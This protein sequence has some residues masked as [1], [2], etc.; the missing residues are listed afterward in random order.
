[1]NTRGEKNKLHN[2]MKNKTGLQP[3]SRTCG[4]NYWFFAA[5]KKRELKR[6]LY[7]TNS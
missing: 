1:M 7:L 6:H 2:V 3:V 4:T 5:G